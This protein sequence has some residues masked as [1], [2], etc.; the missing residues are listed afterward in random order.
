MLQR[1][2]GD[3]KLGRTRRTKH[4]TEQ[5][6]DRGDGDSS[7]TC[8]EEVLNRLCFRRV[9]RLGARA[10]NIDVVD[11]VGRNAGMSQRFTHDILGACA[12]RRGSGHVM[13]IVAA[14]P[15][16]EDRERDCA[17]CGAEIPAL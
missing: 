12:A 6:F 4:V 7:G 15:T 2:H 11:R 8:A 10:M 16:A 14:G 1:E 9:V 17:A 5:T 13:A 3:G